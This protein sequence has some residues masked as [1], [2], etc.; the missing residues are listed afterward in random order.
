MEDQEIRILPNVCDLY[1]LKKEADDALAESP[2]SVVMNSAF[3]ECR[4]RAE[5]SE[6]CDNYEDI[7]SQIIVAKFF[8][9]VFEKRVWKR[10][11]IIVTKSMVLVM[12]RPDDH[13]LKNAFAFKDMKEATAVVPKK[14]VR[15]PSFHHL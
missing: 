4:R 15:S 12:K 3:S 14:E 1:H 11:L 2:L 13:Y 7:S 10:R 5:S 9:Y 6:F 8:A